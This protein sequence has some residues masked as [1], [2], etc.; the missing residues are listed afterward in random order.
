M[1]HL[2]VVSLLDISTRSV[3]RKVRKGRRSV[4]LSSCLTMPRMDTIDIHLFSWRTGET[5][6]GASGRLYGRG[7]SAG[8]E[9]QSGAG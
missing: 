3:P 9:R 4:Y 5:G 2:R 8:I 6:G 7:R 1:G